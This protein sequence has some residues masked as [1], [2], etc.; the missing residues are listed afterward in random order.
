[1]D[2]G[3]KLEKASEIPAPQP[4]TNVYNENK[5]FTFGTRPKQN[6]P[7]FSN[8]TS[9]DVYATVDDEIYEDPDIIIENIREKPDAKV[10]VKN[11]H[12]RKK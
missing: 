9:D 2:F 10:K 12:S 8:E 1:M 6:T 5:L 11:I 3:N 7:G 4:S